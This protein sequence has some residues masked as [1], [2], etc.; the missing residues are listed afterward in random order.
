VTTV[1]DPPR[2]GLRE[3]KKARTRAAI[4][5][6]ALRLFREHGYDE[7]SVEQI[8][9]AAEVSPSTFF[10]YFPT[11]ED[12]V[13]YDAFDPVLIDAFLAQPADAGPIQAMRAAM[14][15]ALGES[16]G[17]WVS[18][19]RERA[20]LLLAVPELRRRM[21]DEFVVGM[22]PFAEALA[23]RVGRSPDDFAV[24]NLVAAVMGVGLGAWLT[25]GSDQDYLASFDAALAHL[26]AGLPL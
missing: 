8:A 9:E 12:V 13:L 5:E 2:S 11:K 4:Q 21:L 24:R 15:A 14:R 7:T 22:E 20:G 10:R 19:Q 18:Q 1:I 17:T 16:A 3:R 25:A 6:H 26:E 23:R